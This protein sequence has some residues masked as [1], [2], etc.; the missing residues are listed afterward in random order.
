MGMYDVIIH[1]HETKL[2]LR[3][4]NLELLE[5]AQSNVMTVTKGLRKLFTALLSSMEMIMECMYKVRKQ[6][7][8][9][10]SL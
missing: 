7:L 10:Q 1:I 6:V 4:C 3:R 9:R 5:D 2:F 8:Q